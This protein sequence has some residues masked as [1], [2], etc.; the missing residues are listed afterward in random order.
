MTRR[1]RGTGRIYQRGNVWWIRFS[2]D[3]NR[4]DESSESTK[5]ADAVKLLNKRLGE[6][7][8]GRYRG[9]T[10]DR[11]AFSDLEQMLE[12]HYHSMRSKSRAEGALAN[13]RRHLGLYRVK[14]ITADV[15]TAY[16]A[17]RRE[18]GASE[19]TI[20]YELAV[21]KKGFNLALRA[22]KLDRKP[23]F[24]SLKVE[25]VRTGF[26]EPKEF[27]AVR[28]QL[29]E[30]LKGL[31]TFAYLTGWRV[32]S[33]VQPLTW[34]QVD[35]KAGIVRLD[36]GTTKSGKGRSFPFDVLPELRTLLKAQRRYTERV[37][38]VTGQ[39]IPWVFHRDGK[40]I[41]SFRRS[42]IT[43]CENAGYVG[44]I[45]HDFRRTAVRR[46]ERAS[47]PRSVAME[48][49]GHKT[50]SVYDRYAIVAEQDLR[51]GVKKMA[52]L[53]EASGSRRGKVLPMQKRPNS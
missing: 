1:L 46:L 25:N 24:P 19:A 3:G 29:P 9:P 53:K 44:K 51:D 47:V 48:L 34:S 20:K 6:V 11:L 17:A 52:G 5:Q 41:R 36:P 50:Q 39:V 13:L 32:P 21:A 35:F 26:F 45:P 49:V 31:V 14:N 7:A 27:N 42:W 23:A 16:V 40:P 22:E 38:R 2:V 18:E 33:E 12:D 37:E 30:D 10:A 43:A 28:D 15:L 4:R 8:A